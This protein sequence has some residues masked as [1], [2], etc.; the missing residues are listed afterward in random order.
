[1]HMVYGCIVDVSLFQVSLRLS[2]A[3]WA[4]Y[5]FPRGHSGGDLETPAFI[6][7]APARSQGAEQ[8]QNG[9]NALVLNT[10]Y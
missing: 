9:D 3:S 1:M 6:L 2:G 5:S 7:P 8:L 10:H 4:Q